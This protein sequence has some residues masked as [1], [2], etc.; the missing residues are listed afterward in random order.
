MVNGAFNL[1]PTARDL[2][3]QRGDPRFQVR[4]RERVQI[5]PDQLA[6]RVGGAGESVVWLHA[7]Q[8]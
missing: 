4:D 2:A 1:L 8:R 7:P 3:L 5:L 6:Q